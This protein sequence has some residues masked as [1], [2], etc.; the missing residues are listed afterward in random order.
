[1]ADV[2]GGPIQAPNQPNADVLAALALLREDVRRLA[3][4][5]ARLAQDG[6]GAAGAAVN[7]VIDDA[8]TQVA[9]TASDIEGFAA[10]VEA[11]MRTRIRGKPITSVLIA[12]SL[13]YAFRC[14]RHRH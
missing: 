1:M 8:K 3:D 12:A 9:Q 7:D 11:D 14:A 5:F 2:A 10:G 13:G 6:R 4:D